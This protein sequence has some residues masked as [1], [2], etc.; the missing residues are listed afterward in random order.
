MHPDQWQHKYPIG[1]NLL[2]DLKHN[3]FPFSS[4]LFLIKSETSLATSCEASKLS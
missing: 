1:W 4:C 3:F 2:Q